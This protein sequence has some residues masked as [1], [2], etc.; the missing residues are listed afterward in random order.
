MAGLDAGGVIGRF[1]TLVSHYYAVANTYVHK[2][3]DK[4][5]Q[6]SFCGKWPPK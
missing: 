1:P 5:I 6:L 4:Y 3:F 2:K